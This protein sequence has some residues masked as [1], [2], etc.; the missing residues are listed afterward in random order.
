MN[1]IISDTR[2][3]LLNKKEQYNKDIDS[4][5]YDFLETDL[6]SFE[7]K[8]INNLRKQIFR[9]YDLVERLDKFEESE[10]RFENGTNI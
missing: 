1:N 3:F 5:V 9:I 2:S 10:V 4:I 6:S 7:L 8:E